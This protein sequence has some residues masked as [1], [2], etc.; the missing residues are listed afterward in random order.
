MAKKHALP[1]LQDAAIR[2]RVRKALTAVRTRLGHPLA[3]GDVH[4]L[5][6]ALKQLRAW[7]RL[8]EDCGQPGAKRLKRSLRDLAAHYGTARD[9]QVQL[10]TLEE[11]Q[12]RS[13]KTFPRSG[14]R[15]AAAVPLLCLPPAVP[16]CTRH[17]TTLDLLDSLLKSDL[18]AADALQQGLG[19]SQR[20]AA[21]R[22]EHAWYSLDTEALHELRKAVKLLANQYALSVNRRGTAGGLYRHLD[23]LGKRLGR[24]HDLAVLRAAL[25]A[26]ADNK[27]LQRELE[28]IE[29]LIDAEEQGLW[30]ECMALSEDCF[31][32]RVR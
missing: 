14:R 24:C 27:A 8:L 23:Q 1:L 29:E 25:G 17:R 26:Q 11:L 28:Q 16:D 20:R 30:P 22:C 32:G 5:R 10:E 21:K 18:P 2:S 3:P 4:Q 7:C 15:L 31:P 6:R 13:G 19:R 12:E 9:A